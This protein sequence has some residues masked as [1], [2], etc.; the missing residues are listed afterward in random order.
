SASATTPSCADT[1]APTVPTGLIASAISCSQISLSWSASSD[2]GGSGLKGYKIYRNG[3][4][5]TQV[6]STVTAYADTGLTAS[7]SNTYR[8]SAIDNA[9][10][11]SAQS[12]SASATTPSCPVP[13]DTIAPSI[14]TGLTVNAISCSQINL[15]WNASTDI[16]G[17]GLKDYSIYCN[18][19]Y[20][21]QVLAPLTT[22]TD[23]GLSAASTYSYTVSAIDNT[24]NESALTIS[25]CATTP[26]CPGTAN[27]TTAPLAPTSLTVSAVSSNRIKLTWKDN[28][29]NEEGFEIERALSASGPWTTISW[30]GANVT[31]YMDSGL[32]SSTIYGYRISAYN[33]M[34]FS[35]YS[36]IT[37]TRT[38][39]NHPPEANNDSAVTMINTPVTINVNV[40]DYDVDDNLD[41]LS[42]MATSDPGHGTL[43][44][45]GNSTFIYT[46]DFNFTGEDT[47]TYEIFDT[48]GDVDSAMVFIKVSSEESPGGNI[49]WSKGFGD[50]LGDKGS[51]VAVDSEHNV[52]MV[53]ALGCGSAD[54]GG[55][56][57]GGKIFIAK[58]SSK[59]Q[60]LWS[61]AFNILGGQAFD[62]V[63][64]SEDNIIMT[65]FFE[66]AVD[67][68]G[69]PL[70]STGSYPTFIVKF[71]KTGEHLWSIAF[72]AGSEK[73]KNITVDS[74]G[75]VLI[76][77]IFTGTLDPGGGPLT[78]NTYLGDIFMAK[79]N[80]KTGEYLWG[81]RFG[82]PYPDAGY[83]IVTDSHDNVI[84]T[85]GI[86][87]TIDFGGGELLSTNGADI[88][89]TKFTKQ[90]TC[91]WSWNLDNMGGDEGHSV[92]VDSSDNIVVT[93]YAYSDNNDI[94]LAKLS[95]EGTCLWYKI[96][97]NPYFNEG[98]DIAVDSDDNIVVTGEFLGSIDVGGGT[99]VTTAGNYDI[100]VAKYSGTTGEY[101]WF[102]A[103]GSTGIDRGEG[104]AVDPLNNIVVTG[105]FFG[106]VDFGTGPLTS[107]GNDFGDIFIVK[108]EP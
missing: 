8:A 29:T 97:N 104:I 67:F 56:E 93:G 69:G 96:F 49:L 6:L 14:P 10:N 76:I 26:E 80:G 43:V 59:G 78:S 31:T 65:G 103:F 66:E 41:Q 106:T 30:V 13:T 89:V 37:G 82:G 47:F 1:T 72:G 50:V 85:G 15:W 21:T 17:S 79:Y 94:F 27:I 84:I 87:G 42:A 62:V 55:G 32:N 68:G 53:G 11:E 33:I 90:G 63:V 9:G 44:N 36:N 101:L 39:Q 71:S 64:D 40:N 98:N 12:T 4:Y 51:S 75:D 74:I 61:K 86:N 16:D 18:G 45:S 108:M 105:E 58:F 60:H 77:G 35:A 73:V 52:I 102:K 46:P 23:T 100:F 54:F 88:F 92:E 95:E 2:S 57:I 38:Q 34:G 91:L 25:Q 70:S 48:E 24:G 28:S 7:S 22:Y 5:L 83:G 81:K 19:S 3:L 99:S 20:L 107:T